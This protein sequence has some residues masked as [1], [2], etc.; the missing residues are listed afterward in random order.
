[1]SYAYKMTVTLPAIDPLIY[2]WSAVKHY[3][4]VKGPDNSHKVLGHFISE[5][6][7]NINDI[8]NDEE[9]KKPGNDC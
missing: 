7:C 8:G 3:F 1:M 4:L 5:V 9:C 2:I 6:C